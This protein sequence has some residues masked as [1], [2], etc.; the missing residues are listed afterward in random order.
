LIGLSVLSDQIIAI[1]DGATTKFPLVRSIGD[2]T[3]PLAGV[4]DVAAARVAGVALAPGAWSV[5]GGYYPS[6]TLA[7]PPPSGASVSIDAAA[8]FLCRFADDDSISN[9]SWRRCSNCGR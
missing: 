2:F 7:S 5:T 9:N 1:G 4:A 3:E 6:L 8:L